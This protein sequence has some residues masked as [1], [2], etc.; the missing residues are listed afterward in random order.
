MRLFKLF[1]HHLQK[2]IREAEEG[3]FLFLVLVVLFSEAIHH[4]VLYPFRRCIPGSLVLPPPVWST[5]L[6]SI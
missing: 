4:S 6:C 3:L 5:I 1:S 2:G